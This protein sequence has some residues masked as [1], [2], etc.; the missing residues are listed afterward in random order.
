MIKKYKI[1]QSTVEGFE[2]IEMN[3]DFSKSKLFD[4]I[5]F[6]GNEMKI[7]QIS[8]Q[9][10]GMSNEEN[11]ITVQAVKQPIKKTSIITDSSL[12]R[13][14][15]EIDIFFETKEIR[16]TNTERLTEKGVTYKAVFEFLQGEWG[17]VQALSAIA[18]PFEYREGDNFLLKDGWSFSQGTPKLLKGGSFTRLDENGRVV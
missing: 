9:I 16:L 6:L 7:T 11:T 12:L 18:F 8:E 13:V 14:N 5:N 1:V 2:G 10:V 15:S 4:E 3:M 17:M